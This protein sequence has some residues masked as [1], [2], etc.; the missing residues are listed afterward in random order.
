MADQSKLAQMFQ[1]LAEERAAREAAAAQGSGAIQGPS[2]PGAIQYAPMQGMVGPTS[3]S[4]I[5]FAQ[6]QPPSGQVGPQHPNDM[7]RYQA[8]EGGRLSEADV[9]RYKAMI[10]SQPQAAQMA[11]SAPQRRG[12]DVG[13]MVPR[14]VID[15]IMAGRHRKQKYRVTAGPPTADL[16]I[17]EPQLGVDVGM[18]T[19]DQRR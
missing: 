15:A 5:Q 12:G 4:D 7:A 14:A 3:P 16:Q 13:Q 11:S 8:M 10:A 6:Q 1:Y 17:G 19:I 9:G 2:G 18:P